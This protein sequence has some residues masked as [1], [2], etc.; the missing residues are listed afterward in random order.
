[1]E[2]SLRDKVDAIES[3]VS[4]LESLFTRRLL[5]DKAKNSLIDDIK[6]YLLYRQDLD[7]GIALLPIMKEMLATV[8]RLLRGHPT[9]EFNA[10]VAEEM[11]E[12]LERYGL[13]P[14]ETTGKID[15]KV[16]EVVSVR[17][18]V[19]RDEGDIVEVLQQGYMLH[20][21]VVRT[22]KVIISKS[23]APDQN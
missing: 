15:P 2:E 5:E 10:S 19:E 13:E 8:D 4:Q 16:H 9:E 14:I 3:K 21:K 22:S 1:M 17:E 18:E 23:I 11:L 6:K 12:L 7:T 20:N